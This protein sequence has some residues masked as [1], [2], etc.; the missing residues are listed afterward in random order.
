MMIPGVMILMNCCFN[1]LSV[2]TP[3]PELKKE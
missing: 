1:K 3:I 2:S